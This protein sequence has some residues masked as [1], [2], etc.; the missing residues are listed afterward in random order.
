MISP[1]FSKPA[2]MNGSY[3]RWETSGL[4][5][6]KTCAPGTSTGMSRSA[7]LW[8]NAPRAWRSLSVSTVNRG[9]GRRLHPSKDGGIRQTPPVPFLSFSNWAG[10][11]SSSP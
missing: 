4:V 9:R 5:A 1:R 10:V 2:A 7:N 6:I 8:K 3:T 11:Y